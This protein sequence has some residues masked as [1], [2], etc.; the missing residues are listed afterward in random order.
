MSTLVPNT[1]STA[2]DHLANERTLLAWVRTSIA[3]IALGIAIAKFS[4]DEN[5]ENAQ[6]T[7]T[8]VGSILV[9]QGSSMILYAQA[10]YHENA[11]RIKDGDFSINTGGINI[12]LASIVL[13]GVFSIIIIISTSK[14]NKV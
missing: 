10:R 5:D 2:R 8:I 13:V 9:V 7:G 3:L 4:S 12:V 1:G 14:W 6:L 11:N